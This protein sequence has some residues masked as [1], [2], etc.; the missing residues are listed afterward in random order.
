MPLGDQRRQVETVLT[1]HSCPLRPLPPL[2]TYTRKDSGHLQRPRW[3]AGIAFEVRWKRDQGWNCP[4]S[5]MVPHLP[6]GFPVACCLLAFSMAC[7]LCSSVMEK[8]GGKGTRE[9]PPCLLQLPMCLLGGLP[10]PGN[11]YPPGAPLLSYFTGWH[12]RD[13]SLTCSTTLSY[14]PRERTMIP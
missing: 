14:Q 3:L 11:T 2:E 9:I 12:G 7:F 8:P 10:G 5:R 6:L 13:C 1:N 4:R